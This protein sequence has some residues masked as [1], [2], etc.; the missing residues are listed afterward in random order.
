VNGNI[1]RGIVIRSMGCVLGVV[2]LQR[3]CICCVLV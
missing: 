3:M 1:L 2:S